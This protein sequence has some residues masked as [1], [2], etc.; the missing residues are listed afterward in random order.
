MCP[1]TPLWVVPTFW[2]L[3]IRPLPVTMYHC[4]FKFL[5]SVLW[6]VCPEL[7]LLSHVGSHYFPYWDLLRLT[8]QTFFPLFSVRIS[9]CSSAWLGAPY[10]DKVNLKLWNSRG[11]FLSALQ[12]LGLKLCAFLGQDLDAASSCCWPWDDLLLPAPT[13]TGINHIPDSICYNYR[14]TLFLRVLLCS[15][16]RPG[17][18][19]LDQCGLDLTGN[20]PASA[21]W[22]LG[23]QVCTP[24]PNSVFNFWVFPCPPTVSRVPV[25][26]YPHWHLF[27]SLPGGC[28][29]VLHCS[30]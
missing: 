6:S 28:T 27:S 29:V 26:L 4:P 8:I 22:G 24:R 7:E 11:A 5:L 16:E 18:Y 13:P 10:V 12:V 17:T 30:S 20:N 19:Y 1:G 25:S 3:W 9:L 2:A 21:S 23:L 15:P 14:Y